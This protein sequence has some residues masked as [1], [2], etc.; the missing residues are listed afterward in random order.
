MGT[1]SLSL[2]WQSWLVH[3]VRGRHGGRFYLG[4]V[5]MSRNGIL[6]RLT[7]TLLVI[8]LCTGSLDDDFVTAV[9]QSPTRYPFCLIE[10]ALICFF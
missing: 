4:S 2:S 1:L 3:L 5:S 7:N 9:R 8:V 10:L 6:L